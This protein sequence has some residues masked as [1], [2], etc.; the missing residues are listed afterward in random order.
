MEGNT[1]GWKSRKLWTTI[2]AMGLICWGFH[3]AGHPH[4][5]Y[6]EF[7]MGILTASGIYKAAS[8]L[9]LKKQQATETPPGA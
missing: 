5:L 8:V 2:L 3:V 9:S 6:G 7:V 1:D 4:D